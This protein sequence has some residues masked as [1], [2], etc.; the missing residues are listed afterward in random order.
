MTGWHSLKRVS[1][2]VDQVVVVVC[3]ALVVVML[4]MSST[5]IFY[6]FILD[7]PLTWSYSLTRLFLPWLAL[8]SVTVAYKRGEHVAISFLLRRIPRRALR[9]I[10]VFN[11]FVV[12]LFGLALLWYGIDFF[13]DSNQLFMVSDQLQVSHKWTAI[14]VPITGAIMC[15]HLLSGTALVEIHEVIDE[16]D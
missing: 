3:V 14:S 2:A 12:G 15:V 13:L 7:D 1:D 9:V 16:V 5:G 8:L 6:Q 11:L 10:Q 4:S